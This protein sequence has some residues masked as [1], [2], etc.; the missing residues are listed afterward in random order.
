MAIET[1][2]VGAWGDIKTFKTTLGFSFPKPLVHLDLDLGFERASNRILPEFSIVRIPFNQHL[3]A[4]I[5]AQGDIITK[6]YR[7]PIKFPGQPIRG[8]LSVWEEQMIPD[9]V[10]IFGT[11]R[12]KSILLDTGT[13]MWN[14]DKDAQL[15]RAQ[16][17]GQAQNKGRESLLP[18]EYALP[19]QE[20]RA[21]LGTAKQ[22]N[23]NLYIPH[24]I[25]GKYSSS[26]SGISTRIGDTWDGWNHLGAAMDVITQTSRGIG[27][28]VVG[29]AQ[30]QFPQIMIETCGYSISAEGQILQNPTFDILLNYINAM[31]DSDTQKLL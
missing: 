26:L 21:L 4:Q 12:I 29:Q 20:M 14:I 11:E 8:L 7:F 6:Q 15:E 5:L 30:E 25:G 3:T 2:N 10:L 27:P 28:M 19:N 24:H 18:I 23:K 9:M 31:R 13:V 22:M 1:L 16:I 17:N